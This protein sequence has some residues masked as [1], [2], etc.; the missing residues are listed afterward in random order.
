MS[1]V[2]G[3]GDAA[4]A[5][6]GD[7]AAAGAGDTVRAA[8][9]RELTW[10]MVGCLAAAGLVLFA[11][12]RTWLVEQTSRPAPLPP[13]RQART[14]VDVAP[15]AQPLALVGCAG[16]VALTATRGGVRTVLGVL[17]AGCGLGVAAA[18]AA[19]V[20][21]GAPAAWPVVAALGGVGL[22]VGG[23]L[24]VRRGRRWPA[25]GARYERRAAASR[26]RPAADGG[27]P[28]TVATWEALDRG[29]D[30]TA[31]DPTADRPPAA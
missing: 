20:V 4:G 30:P 8:R 31:D 14:G 13:L 3:A 28:D 12:T 21:H 29:D 10:V 23:V 16:A 15:W 1:G 24:T 11:A 6:A 7:S 19:A 2:A 25:M 5:G 26:T 17:L 18:S 22:T 9:R 27:A